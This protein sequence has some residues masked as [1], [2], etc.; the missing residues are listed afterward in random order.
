M[1]RD[2]IT[3][4]KGQGMKRRALTA[5]TGLWL[6]VG[7]PAA[8]CAAAPAADAEPWPAGLPRSLAIRFGERCTVELIGV[9]AGEYLMGSLESEP[10]RDKDEG[11]RTVRISRPFYLG[12]CELTQAQWR[13]AGMENLSVTVGDN[14]PVTRC[15]WTDATNFMGAINRRHGAELPKG[16]VFRLPTEAE[17][18][19]ACRAGT[20]GPYYFGTNGAA[21][22]AHMWHR[23]NSGGRMQPVGGRIPNAWGFHDMLG[24]V[25]EWCWDFAA[26]TEAVGAVVDPLGPAPDHRWLAHVIRGGSYN[27]P[28]EKCR[29]ANRV[30]NGYTNKRRDHMGL[31]LA[32]G[33]PFPESAMPLPPAPEP[34]PAPRD[35][36]TLPGLSESSDADT[37][38]FLKTEG[39]P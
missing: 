14:L 2:L 27:D 7:G 1:V 25:F 29:A 35:D 22:D 3:V 38:G 8:V 26:P 32:A 30:G 17:W 31:R 23:G 37:P 13:A 15:S 11:P 33:A 24:N 4:G 39:G 19:Y 36:S 18:E 6:S 9:P 28:A 12:R 34:A 21:A 10:L 5:M 20:T 16:F